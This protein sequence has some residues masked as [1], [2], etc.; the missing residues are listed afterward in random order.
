MDN[1]KVVLKE[2]W[3]ACGYQSASDANCV[4]WIL[5]R[6]GLLL[7]AEAGLPATGFALTSNIWYFTS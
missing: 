1:M 7:L 5:C 4:M 3:T 2:G 6:A